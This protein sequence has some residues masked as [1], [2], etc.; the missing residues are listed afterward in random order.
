MQPSQ[1]QAPSSS[2]SSSTPNG[3]AL[4]GSASA[5]GALPCGSHQ[6]PMVALSITS[7]TNAAATYAELLYTL[8]CKVSTCA[9]SPRTAARSSCYISPGCKVLCAAYM[10]PPSLSARLSRVFASSTARYCRLCSLG[11]P[12]HSTDSAAL[13][14]QKHYACRVSPAAEGA[15]CAII[16]VYLAGP[17]CCPGTC[18]WCS[19]RSLTHNQRRHALIP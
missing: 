19:L 18:P 5:A 15:D 12:S 4:P 16:F 17:S 14:D 3:S 13:S 6:L 7:S 11:E 9:A 8:K 1:H 2:S 10:V